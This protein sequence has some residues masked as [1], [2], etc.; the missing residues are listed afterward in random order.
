[1]PGK[2]LLCL[3]YS[4]YNNYTDWKTYRLHNRAFL[5]FFVL[6]IAVNAFAGGVGGVKDALLG[7][8]FMLILL[9]LFALRFMGAG[10]IKALIGVG[11]MLGFPA[12]A[13]SL[14]FSLIAMEADVLE[15]GSTFFLPSCAFTPPPGQSFQAWRVNGQDRDAGTQITVAESLS[16][17]PLWQDAEQL[18]VS[19]DSSQIQ[20]DAVLG[21]RYDGWFSVKPSSAIA[22]VRFVKLDGE[23]PNGL[24]METDGY[25][26][27]TPETSGVFEFTVGLYLPDGTC[28]D[29]TDCVIEVSGVSAARQEN[30]P[31][32]ADTALLPQLP[33]PTEQP[34]ETVFTDVDSTAWY[35]KDLDWAYRNGIIGGYGDGTFRNY[36]DIN[37][38]MSV[39]TLARMGKVNLS[40][41][42][43]WPVSGIP[44]GQWYT[45]EARWAKLSSILPSTTFAGRA[46]LERGQMAL[47]L[48]NYL[49]Y[50]GITLS[51][52]TKPVSF[53]DAEDMSKEENDALQILYRVGIFNGRGDRI[54]DPRGHTTRGHLVA[55]LH[56]MNAFVEAHTT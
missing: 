34:T 24:E 2:I 22:S 41:Y 31:G 51:F 36:I 1:M 38:A 3:L 43:N 40:L 26:T 35:C 11:A 20:R 6:G 44:A 8:A 13:W 52:P 21:A 18:S 27:G 5:L 14:A 30:E 16:V 23:F 39:V 12:A 45:K 37:G 25:I 33:F 19:M 17:T 46:Y 48:V 28:A 4:L 29:T 9:P 15:R 49:K 56:R 32:M 55:L 42:E 10:D 54:M 50:K 47:L 7:G 53:A